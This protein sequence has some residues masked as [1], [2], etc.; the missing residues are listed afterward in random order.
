LN[1]ERRHDQ[2]LIM[3]LTLTERGTNVSGTFVSPHGDMKVTGDFADGVLRLSTAGNDETSVTFQAKMQE[4]GT[5]AGHISTS[6]GD[7]TFTAERAK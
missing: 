5:L 3:G 4:D 6:R 1:E 7:M 2:T